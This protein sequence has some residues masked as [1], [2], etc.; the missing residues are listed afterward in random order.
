MDCS[1]NLFGICFKKLLKWQNWVH[2]TITLSVSNGKK[3]LCQTFKNSVFEGWFN[4][5][6][7]DVLREAES[8]LEFKKITS[9]HQSNRAT[10][11]SKI[12]PDVPPKRFNAYRKLLSSI[13][14]ETDEQKLQAK[15]LSWALRANGYNGATFSD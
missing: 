9:Y 13:A 6:V 11:G 1:N 5:K 15:L 2:S 10:F 7:S 14:Q 12:T 4:W 3:Y 8:T